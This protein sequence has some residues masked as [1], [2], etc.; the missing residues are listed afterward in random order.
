ML[1]ILFSIFFTSIVLNADLVHDAR[2]H[3]LNGNKVK[4]MELLTQSCDNG[5]ISGCNTLGMM[6]LRGDGVRQNKRKASKLLYKACNGS[7]YI[8]NTDACFTLGVM[9]YRGEGVQLDKIEAKKLFGKAC[10]G[11][12]SDGCTN[13]KILLNEGY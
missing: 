10:D 8:M 6:Y 7:E 4:A 2:Q 5:R 13:Y 3:Y 1:K 11:G 9:H 12:H